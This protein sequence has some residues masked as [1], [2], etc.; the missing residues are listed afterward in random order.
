MVKLNP[1]ALTLKRLDV[2][3][4]VAK[5]KFDQKVKSKDFKPS[6]RVLKNRK[7]EQQKQNIQK[8]FFA[9]VF[10]FDKV[11]QPKTN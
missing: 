9:N 1:Y 7:L 3:K 4:K 8:K 10:D 11:S 6:K 2:R 5:E